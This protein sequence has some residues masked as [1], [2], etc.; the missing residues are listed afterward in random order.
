MKQQK[1][2]PKLIF[3]LSMLWG[4]SL[5]L[6]QF[7]YHL[8]MTDGF[9]DALEAMIPHLPVSIAVLMMCWVAGASVSKAQIKI[10]FTKRHFI[11]TAIL[12]LFFFPIGLFFLFGS[13]KY[14]ELGR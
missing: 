3:A 14:S 2:S 13:T 6:V 12:C 5:I 11:V 7:V 9:V 4:F 10:N 8:G 1:I